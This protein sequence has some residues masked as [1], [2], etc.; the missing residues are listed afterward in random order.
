MRKSLL[1]PKLGLTMEEGALIEWMRAPGDSFQSG[2][3]L[4]VIE[5]EKVATEIAADHAGR[6]EK[7]LVAA[8]ETVPVGTAVAYWDDGELQPARMQSSKAPEASVTSVAPAV[9]TTE[10]EL[11]LQPQARPAVEQVLGNNPAQSQARIIATPYARVVAKQARIDLGEVVGSGPNGRIRASDVEAWIDR[12]APS[13]CPAQFSSAQG[14]AHTLEKASATQSTMARRL[15]AAKQETPHFYLAAEAE[16]SGLLDLRAALNAKG[17]V[18]RL[19]LTHFLLASVCRALRDV[20]DANRVWRQE[21]I[22]RF[23][24]CDVGI[25]VNTTRGLLVPVVRNSSAPGFQQLVQQ[26]EH[27]IQRARDGVLN[28]A[29]LGGGAVTISNAGMFNVTYMTPIIN[30]GQ[31]LILGVGA[32]RELFRPLPDGQPGLRRELGLVLAADHRLHDG[33]S[34]M[35][36]LNAVIGYLEQPLPLLFDV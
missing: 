23:H 24:H 10:P 19:T 32:I 35:Q 18:P 28:A 26:S 17:G 3:G 15:V 20:P 36:F 13:A 7:I 22:V 14:A 6:L 30:P 16:V 27:V 9:L 1:M 33:V 11:A 12:A 8:G 4:F 34:G 25:A 2:D 29:D 21:G 5:T 31:S